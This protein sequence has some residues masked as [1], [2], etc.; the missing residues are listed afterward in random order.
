MKIELKNV[1]HSEFASH[2]TYCFEA[3]IYIDG[4]RA[5]T[6]ENNGQGGCN[7]YHPR[8]LEEAI[9][10]HAKT[11]PKVQYDAHEFDQDAD[12]LIGDLLVQHLHAKDLK[13][14]LNKRILF[15]TDDGLLKETF[16]LERQKME[17]ILAS[18]TI[19]TQLKA[20]TILN[21]LP[22]DQALSLYVNHFKGANHA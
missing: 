15:F 21:L 13:R 14:A 4:K 12:T 16:N 20:Q 1:K 22:F 11:L 18:P 8:E 10:A 19:K 2:E 17:N 5:G 9:K 3:A 6:V 7:F